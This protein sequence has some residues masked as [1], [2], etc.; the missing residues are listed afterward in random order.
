M[1]EYG[2]VPPPQDDSQ[3]LAAGGA[4]RQC[5]VSSDKRDGLVARNSHGKSLVGRCQPEQTTRI[6]ADNICGGPKYHKSLGEPLKHEHWEPEGGS[7]SFGAGNWKREIDTSDWRV[8]ERLQQEAYC[9]KLSADGLRKR[10]FVRVGVQGHAHLTD[11]GRRVDVL[12][13]ASANY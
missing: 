9:A 5:I 12:D 7:R 3:Y 13:S 4:S 6:Q 1:N 10:P 11:T 8:R 2:V